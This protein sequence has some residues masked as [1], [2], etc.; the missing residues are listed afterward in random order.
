MKNYTIILFLCTFYISTDIGNLNRKFSIV[1]ASYNNKKYYERNLSS[2]F[3]QNYDN[4]ELIYIDDCSTDG[5]GELVENFIKENCPKCK[6]T[7]I[8]NE[9]SMRSP[10]H[11]QYLAIHSVDPSSIIVILDGDDWF[12]H[13]DVLKILNEAYSNN[14]IWLTYGQ[15]QVYPTGAL[16][17]NRPYSEDIIKNNA[18]RED[19]YQPS[20]LR[21]YYA[22][23]FQAIS[24]KD[25]LYDGIIFKMT[26]DLAVS[27]PMIEMTGGKFKFISE[28]MCIYNEDNDLNEHKID[29]TLQHGLSPVI[30]SRTK[31]NP[32]K[33]SEQNK[34][35]EWSN[36]KADIIVFSYDRPMQL[37]AF[38][39]SLN[40][41]VTGIDNIYIIY[42]TSNSDFQKAYYQLDGKYNLCQFIEQSNENFKDLVLDKGFNSKSKHIIFAVDDIIIK[43]YIDINKCIKILEETDAY[44][45]FMR[46]GKNINYSYMNSQDITTPRGV[47]LGREISGLKFNENIFAWQFK[48]GE[49][50][51]RYCNNLDMTL[52]KKSKIY[53]HVNN[54]S[55]N[56]PNK[57]E[58]EWSF[59]IENVKDEVGLCFET[60]KIVNIPLN[61]V[62]NDLP[63]NKNMNLYTPKELLE[64]Y[65]LG[66]RINID[67]FYK[68][69]NKSPHEPIHP[70][71]QK[72]GNL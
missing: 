68:L 67:I 16:G 43:D 52:Y 60:S 65:M 38:L 10:L 39:E 32:L 62:Q 2:I 1:T 49:C 22:W 9:V 25:V 30:R 24:L 8:K 7:F 13:S 31:Y 57:L 5:T 53:S 6:V 34:R 69:N 61:I 28:I 48:Y 41:Y 11:N 20:H 64:L 40:K 54:L 21:T 23:L 42:K 44:A 50:D 18:Y 59:G 47:N 66:F 58:E 4:Y 70:I 29:M 15:F 3:N 17:F 35:Y 55:F 72:K 27:M 36:A 14:D 37:D 45:F 26:G 63:N 12:P 19:P 33:M 56:S 71:L 46:L 51:W